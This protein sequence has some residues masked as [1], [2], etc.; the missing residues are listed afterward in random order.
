LF[1]TGTLSFSAHWDVRIAVILTAFGMIFSVLI[2]L[3]SFGVEGM[4]MMLTVALLSGMVA[5]KIKT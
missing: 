1:I 4:G 5:Y 2:N 3:I